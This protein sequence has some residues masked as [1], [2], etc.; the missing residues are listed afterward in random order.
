MQFSV[1]YSIG[2]E[3]KMQHPQMGV[4]A[5]AF[6]PSTREGEAGVQPHARIRYISLDHELGT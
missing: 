2:L 3:H 4:L 1:F 6:N 5:H